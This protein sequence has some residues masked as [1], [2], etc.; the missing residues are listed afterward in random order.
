MK[1]LKHKQERDIPVSSQ[2]EFVLRM[3]LKAD[4]EE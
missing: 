2:W 4:C 1:E 3:E